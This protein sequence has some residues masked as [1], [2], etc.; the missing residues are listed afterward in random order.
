MKRK[1][2][3]LEYKHKE[4]DG[5]HRYYTSLLNLCRFNPLIG[6]KYPTL[7]RK[8][9]EEPYENKTVIIHYGELIDKTTKK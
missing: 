7:A 9:F 2:Y 3:H 5:K 6:V 1:I 8:S 4:G